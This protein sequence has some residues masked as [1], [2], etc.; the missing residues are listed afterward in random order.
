DASNKTL[1]GIT[2]PWDGPAALT[3][4]LEGSKA[5]ASSKFLAAKLWS[6]LAAPNPEPALV[7]DL[8]KVFRD[9]KL[10]ILALVRAVFMRPEFRLAATRTALV[11]SPVEWFV[12]LTAALGIDEK[13]SHPEWWLKSM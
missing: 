2:A 3:E 10:S 9:S 13:D 6:Y 5:E 4:I 1:F 11:R 7:A 12:A 8:A